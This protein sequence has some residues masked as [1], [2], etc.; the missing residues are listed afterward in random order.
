MAKVKK[1]EVVETAPNVEN[2]AEQENVSQEVGQVEKGEIEEVAPE[3]PAPEQVKPAPAQAAKIESKMVS[4]H[5]MEY[6]DSIIAQKRY[7]IRKHSDVKV[8]SDVAAILVT[9]KKAYRV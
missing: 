9:S 2:I 5:V 6:V 3:A 4:I 1:E 7:T 8:P